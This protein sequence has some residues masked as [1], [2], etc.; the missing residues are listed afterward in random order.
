MFRQA[1]KWGLSVSAI[2]LTTRGVIFFFGMSWENV[3]LLLLSMLI[4]V[5]AVQGDP[6][7]G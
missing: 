3:M 2:Y 4:V 6:E 7:L 5:V 1:L